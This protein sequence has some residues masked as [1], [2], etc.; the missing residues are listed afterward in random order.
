MSTYFYLIKYFRKVKLFCRSFA[1]LNLFAEKVIFGIDISKESMRNF[2]GM[3]EISLRAD[4]DM[5]NLV[6]SESNFT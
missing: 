2:C 6:I 5:S 3:L 1:N 4:T